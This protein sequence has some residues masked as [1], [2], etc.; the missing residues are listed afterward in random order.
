MSLIG[1]LPIDLTPPAFP[2]PCLYIAADVQKI[3]MWH[4]IKKKIYI[5]HQSQNIVL[6]T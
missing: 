4:L 3:H 6:Q 1:A 2:L 5:V